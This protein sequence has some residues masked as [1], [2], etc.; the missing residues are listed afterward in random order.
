M[1][2]K[3]CALLFVL[4]NSTIAFDDNKFM[5]ARQSDGPKRIYCALS[6]CILAKMDIE[7]I[8]S[9]SNRCH[10]T[11]S[12]AVEHSPAF[13]FAFV[14]FAISVIVFALSIS[15]LWSIFTFRN[16]WTKCANKNITFRYKLLFYCFVLSA[17][18][19]A[20]ESNR[21]INKN[22]TTLHLHAFKCICISKCLCACRVQAA[23]TRS[24]IVIVFFERHK[25]VTWWHFS[26][27]NDDDPW[28][29]H[30]HTQNIKSK[31]PLVDWKSNRLF[32]VCRTL[33]SE[34]PIKPNGQNYLTPHPKTQTDDEGLSHRQW[35]R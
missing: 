21:E 15:F 17:H 16:L 1:E 32:S 22:R 29:T 18:A 11:I 7:S 19:R 33:Y 8:D 30:T 24:T 5:S 14:T 9:V 13:A 31:Y 20:C 23:G 28:Y 12:I 25:S 35:Q 2:L 27:R 4:R 34:F 10:S 3:A 26:W 6:V